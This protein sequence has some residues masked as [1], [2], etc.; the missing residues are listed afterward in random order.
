MNSTIEKGEKDLDKIAKNLGLTRGSIPE[1]LR[2]GGGEPLGSGRDLQQLVFSDAT[3]TQGK[4]GGPLAIGEDRLVLVKVAAHHKAEVK[5]LAAVHDDIVTLLKQERGVA[6]AKV[7]ADAAISR[8]E[9][10]E[11]LD[12]LAKGWSVTA[13]PAR[14][15]SRGDP[16]IP[17]ALR[18]AIFEAARPAAKPVIKAASIENGSAV[19]VVTRSRVADT[20]AN[21]QM[22]QQQNAALVERSAQGD[23]AA[24]VTEAKRKA[25]IVKNAGVFE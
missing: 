10:G 4:I 25:K 23:I 19:F 2:G 15:V 22:V 17:A 13:E 9:G 6:A 16:S 24:Y 14:F 11:K 3:L 1:F 20:T 8:L 5:P 18:T 12:A 7:A 21:P